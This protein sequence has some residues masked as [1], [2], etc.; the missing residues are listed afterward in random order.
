MILAGAEL[1]SFD[2]YNLMPYDLSKKVDFKPEYLFGYKVEQYYKRF[3]NFKIDA[4]FQ[5]SNQ[6]EYEIIKKHNCDGKGLLDVKTTFNN[7]YFAYYLLPIYCIRY[8]YHS[9]KCLAYM[10][11]QTGEISGQVQSN[12]NFDI[13]SVVFGFIVVIAVIILLFVF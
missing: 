7:E 5:I 4:E 10:N 11:G 9:K 8:K 1:Y 3:F 12:F 13:L 6:I 2:F